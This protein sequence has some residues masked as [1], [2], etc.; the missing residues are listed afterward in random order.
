MPAATARK[1]ELRSVGKSG[2]RQHCIVAR[3][4]TASACPCRWY[5]SHPPQPLALLSLLVP[6]DD[7]LASEFE[8]LRLLWAGRREGEEEASSLAALDH[9]DEFRCA[10]ARLSLRSGRLQE[11]L[12]VLRPEA[13][14]DGALVA[15]IV[16]VEDEC[17][18]VADE[19]GW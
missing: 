13:V 1:G 17:F 7:S 11:L 5:F 6:D 2:S 18:A 8:A 3:V 9:L 19:V 12:E 4:L 10:V 15:A 16:A 14:P